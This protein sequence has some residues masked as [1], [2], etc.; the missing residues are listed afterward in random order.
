MLSSGLPAA[1]YGVWRLP[2]GINRPWDFRWGRT[3]RRSTSDTGSIPGGRTCRCKEIGSY[4]QA[5]VLLRQGHTDLDGNGDGEACER[6][7]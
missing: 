4:Q 1:G 3:S 5:Q 6:L 7:R 2:G